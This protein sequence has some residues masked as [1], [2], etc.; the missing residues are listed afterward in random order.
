MIVIR[1]RKLYKFIFGKSMQAGTHTILTSFCRGSFGLFALEFTTIQCLITSHANINESCIFSVRT[2]FVFLSIN[3]W[4]YFSLWKYEIN[5]FFFVKW[6]RL[7]LFVLTTKYEFW[8]SMNFTSPGFRSSSQS[9]QLTGWFV[10][11]LWFY[12]ARCTSASPHVPN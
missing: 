6:N 1:K 8:N 9:H 4:F 10:K 5:S 3:Y 12:R 11:G 2:A 7:N